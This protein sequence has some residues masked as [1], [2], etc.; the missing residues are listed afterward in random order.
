MK[1]QIFILVIMVL[2]VLTGCTT[3]AEILNAQKETNYRLGVME[4]KIG[5]KENDETEN[6]DVAELE[7]KLAEAN[8]KVEKL[9]SVISATS[10]DEIYIKVKFPSDGNFYKEAYDEVQFYSD[11]ECTQEIETP[12]F[13]SKNVDNAQAKNS[14]NIYCVLTESGTI[15]YCTQPPYLITEDE[16]EESHKEEP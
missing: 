1:K 11:P 4:E 10:K 9:E 5:K 14:L 6:K 3:N 8:K 7:N 16:Y 15:V 12:S 13:I 2:M